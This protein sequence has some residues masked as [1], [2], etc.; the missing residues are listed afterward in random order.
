MQTLQ[1]FTLNFEVKI[2]HFFLQISNKNLVAEKMM[3]FYLYYEILRNYYEIL[4][5]YY[6]NY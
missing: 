1:C 4:R 6:E 2:S 5:N 3:L